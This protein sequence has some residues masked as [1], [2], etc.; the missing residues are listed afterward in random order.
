VTAEAK[1]EGKYLRCSD[2]TLPAEDIALG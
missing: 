2:P 1:L